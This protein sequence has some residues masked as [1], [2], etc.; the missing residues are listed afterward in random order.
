MYQKQYLDGFMEFM[1]NLYPRIDRESVMH[2]VQSTL[3][4]PYSLSK[5]LLFA[6]ENGW[7]TRDAVKRSA[8][9]AYTL[10]DID[11][12]LIEVSWPHYTK[13]L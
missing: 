11:N 8:G 5:L 9:Y 1:K 7:I 12:A 6:I 10:K 2:D 4:L 13:H 3:E